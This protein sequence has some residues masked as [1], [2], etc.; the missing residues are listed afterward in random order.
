MRSPA[1]RVVLPPAAVQALVLTVSSF[2]YGYHRD[3]LYFRMLPPAW[4]YVDQP[5][6]TPL[7]ARLTTHLADEVWA[8]RIPATLCASLSVVVLALV[9]ARLG[10]G[11]GAQALCAWGCAT[12][13][14][15][16]VLGHV[17]LTSTVDLLLLAL[18]VLAVLRATQGAAHGWLWAGAAAGAA[19]YNRLL[20]GVVAAGLVLGMLVLGPRRPF[21]SLELWAGAILGAVVAL[22]NL[23]YQATNEWPQLAM[24]EALSRNNA[25]DVRPQLLPLLVIMMGPPLTVVWAVGVGWLLRRERRARVGY[26]VVGFLVLVVFTFVS[27]AQ[28]HYPVHLVTVMYAA[29][30]VPVSRWLASRRAWRWSALVLLAVNAAVSVALALPVVPVREVG[31]TPVS[32]ISPL[33]KDQVGWPRYVQQVATA[34]RTSVPR[35][36]EVIASNYGEAGAVARFGPALG[37]PPPVSGHNAL[38]DVRRPRDGSSVVLVLGNQYHDVRPLFDSCRVVARLDDGVGVDNEE[39][40]VPVALCEGPR[41]AWAQLWPRFHHLD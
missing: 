12:A 33:V 11:R 41:A 27:G 40:G 16:L 32:A 20:V 9:T 21:R 39:Q 5:P 6:L 1:W 30:C 8:M 23:L 29:G 37:L 2:G 35:P 7:L 38:G 36:T 3:E 18:V 17:L 31:S 24:G 15:P 4:G 26:L 22:P 14:V 25:A 19:S 13:A 34:Y 10:G 28:P